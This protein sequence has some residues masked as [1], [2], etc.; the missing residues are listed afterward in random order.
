MSSI[1]LPA[2]LSA[3]WF[4]SKPPPPP[5]FLSLPLPA[6]P[7]PPTLLLFSSLFRQ[8]SHLH[9]FLFF[10]KFSFVF[11]MN[12]LEL[13]RDAEYSADSVKF[14]SILRRKNQ[15]GSNKL[16][17]TTVQEGLFLSLFHS[18]T[19]SLQRSRWTG[20]SISTSSASCGTK[21]A[22]TSAKL[23]TTWLRLTSN[24]SM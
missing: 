20:R 24:M 8:E 13:I 11:S 21:L 7:S 14:M 15:R 4:I 3:L 6:P 5:P 18:F 19:R 2:E 23:A 9:F 16:F 17:K 22:A 1:H 10:V 12:I